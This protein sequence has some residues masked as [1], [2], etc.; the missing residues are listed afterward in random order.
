VSAV[1][2]MQDGVSNAK[3]GR[4]QAGRQAE[5]PAAERKG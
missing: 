5:V 4:K 1:P 2:G 3:G